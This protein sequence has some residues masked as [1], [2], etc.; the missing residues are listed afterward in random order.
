MISDHYHQR[1]IDI[2]NVVQVMLSTKHGVVAT[3][4]V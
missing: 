2:S 4:N 1:A 3:K